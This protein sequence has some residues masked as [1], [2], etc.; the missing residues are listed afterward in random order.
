MVMISPEFSADLIAR[1]T[2]SL[3]AAVYRGTRWFCSL[4]PG[5]KR[6]GTYRYGQRSF[7]VSGPSL[8]NSL[9]L[10]VR[11]LVTDSNTVLY[12]AKDINFLFTRAYGT[13]P[14][15]ASVT[16]SAVRIAARTEIFLL[17]Y[18]QD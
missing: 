1:V 15:S 2:A 17:T 8:W 14:Y 16:A 13:S 10:T 4:V 9:P 3:T 18:L 12:E 11:R 6:L 5:L 7:Y